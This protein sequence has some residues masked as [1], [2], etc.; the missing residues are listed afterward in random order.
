ML[1]VTK[2]AQ[3][4]TDLDELVRTEGG[5]PDKVLTQAKLVCSDWIRQHK[6]LE[7]VAV[8]HAGAMVDRDEAEMSLRDH[9]AGLALQACVSQIHHQGVLQSLMENATKDNQTIEEYTADVAY[10]FAQGMLKIRKDR[11]A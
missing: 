6:V 8:S 3:I 11:Y 1:D 2:V 5:E 10:D 7:T 4:L 9:F